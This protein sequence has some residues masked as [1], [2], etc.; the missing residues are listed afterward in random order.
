[1]ALPSIDMALKLIEK[2]MPAGSGLRSAEIVALWL[3]S[4]EP[5]LMN[6]WGPMIW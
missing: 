2:P 1:M 4:I 5:D 6:D 3:T